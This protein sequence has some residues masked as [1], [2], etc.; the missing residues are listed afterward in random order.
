MSTEKSKHPERS[1]E[2]REWVEK[3]RALREVNPELYDDLGG[4]DE[5][6]CVNPEEF[7]Y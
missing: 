7:G 1:K 3:A 5:E 6:G 2:S 4:D